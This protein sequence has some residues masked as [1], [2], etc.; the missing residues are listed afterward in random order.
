MRLLHS[1]KAARGSHTADWSQEG[2]KERQD[3]SPGKVLWSYNKR[4]KLRPPGNLLWSVLHIHLFRFSFKSAEVVRVK[5]YFSHF[6]FWT[7]VFTPGSQVKL[8]NLCFW[9]ELL[10]WTGYVV[11]CHLPEGWSFACHTSFWWM[12]C[13]EY[14]KQFFVL[15]VPF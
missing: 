6:T 10:N 11:I 15:Q 3:H 12:Q 1:V 2:S 8:L 13:L 4:M 9:Q 5:H 14:F 7:F